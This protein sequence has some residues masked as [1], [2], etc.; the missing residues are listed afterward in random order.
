MSKRPLVLFSGGLDSTFVLWR[1][2]KNNRP[3]DYVY[4]EGGQGTRKVN[5]E[6]ETRERIIRWME[7]NRAEG[8]RTPSNYN[9]FNVQ[10]SKVSLA[11]GVNTSWTQPIAWIIGAL[12]VADSDRHSCV[13]VGYVMGDEAT[14]LIDQ[15]QTA[16]TALWRISKTGEPIS[17]EFPLRITSKTTI[18]SEMPAELYALT[19]VCETPAGTTIDGFKQCGTCRACET[20]LVEEYRWSLRHGGQVLSERHAAELSNIASRKEVLAANSAEVVTE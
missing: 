12:S 3:S 6:M 20:R 1:H 15:M 5:C 19:W 7:D 9:R 2:F 11:T 13:E 18:L 14:Q 17:L 4:I 8:E 16:W 10:P